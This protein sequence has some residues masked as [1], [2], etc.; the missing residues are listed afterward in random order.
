M[1]KLQT[2]LPASVMLPPYRLKSLLSQALEL[3]TLRCQHHNTTQ[4]I[5]LSNA[6]LLVDHC[7]PKESFPMHTIQVK[8]I[9][10]G[11]EVAC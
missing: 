5:G 8:K 1:D 7:C 9:H 2:F 6:S 3:Q 4:G 10:T 11:S